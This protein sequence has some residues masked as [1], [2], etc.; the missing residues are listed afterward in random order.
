MNS[1]FNYG[2]SGAEGT[3]EGGQGGALFPWAFGHPS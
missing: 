1:Y 2:G 3:G